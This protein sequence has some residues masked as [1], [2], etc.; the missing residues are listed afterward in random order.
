MNNLLILLFW[1]HTFEISVE[2]GE[3][4]G[5]TGDQAAKRKSCQV[6]ELMRLLV[7][8]VSERIAESR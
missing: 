5:K 3:E 7:K 4:E 2:C 6:Q 8:T 1:S